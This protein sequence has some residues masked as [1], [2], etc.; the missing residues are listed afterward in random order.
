M[1]K[2]ALVALATTLAFAGCGKSEQKTSATAPPPAPAATPATATAPTAAP[3]AVAQ[4]PPEVTRFSDPKVQQG[5][6]VY[7][8]WCTPCHGPGPMHPGTQAL[9]AK[10]KGA[11]PAALQDRTDLTPDLTKFYV[12]TGVSIMPPF[13]KTEITDAELDALAAYLARPR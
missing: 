7:H 4:V 6:D 5:Y 10:Y 2:L 9:E 12:R 11:Q 3:A 13:R 8:K 1:K